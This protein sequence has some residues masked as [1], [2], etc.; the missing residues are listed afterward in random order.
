MEL[1]ISPPVLF[2]D[3]PTT[4]LDASTA[5]SVMLLLKRSVLSFHSMEYWRTCLKVLHK[6]KNAFVLCSQSEIQKTLDTISVRWFKLIKGAFW[7]SLVKITSHWLHNLLKTDFVKW[8]RCNAI[9]VLKVVYFLV[10]YSFIRLAVKGRTIIFSIHQPRFSI[11]RL[12][13]SLMMLS[14]GQVVYHGPT[15]DTLG[16]FSSIGKYMYTI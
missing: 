2:L 4:G 15:K 1:I 12:F 13:D 5:N 9:Y 14:K 10:S 7:M 6:R 11:Y 3:E 8:F 16:Y